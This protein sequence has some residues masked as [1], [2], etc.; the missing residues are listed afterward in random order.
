[1]KKRNI[2]KLLFGILA[3]VLWIIIYKTYMYISQNDFQTY[4]KNMF[5]YFP[6]VTQSMDEN[7][8]KMSR[9]YNWYSCKWNKVYYQG[10]L[11]PATHARSFII[12]EGYGIDTKTNILYIWKTPISWLDIDSLQFIDGLPLY[13]QDIYGYYFVSQQPWYIM[14]GNKKIDIHP[15]QKLST[16]T[17]GLYNITNLSQYFARDDKNL[18][19]MWHKIDDIDPNTIVP[20]TVSWNTTS[21]YFISENKIFMWLSQILWADRDSFMIDV[22]DQTIAYD[23]YHTY[24]NGKILK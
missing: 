7:T 23:K 11:L 9:K 16:T 24:K 12:L 14:Q 19:Y 20:I 15:L 21:E 18:Y 2:I 10:Q 1:M 6:I 8:L 4:K 22:D 17:G 5:H 3:V 13:I